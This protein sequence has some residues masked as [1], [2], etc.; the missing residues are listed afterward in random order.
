MKVLGASLAVL[1]AALPIAQKICDLRCADAA[2][3]RTARAPMAE[4]SLSH[5]ENRP[6]L[7][8]E[9]PAQCRHGRGSESFVAASKTGSIGPAPI[10]PARAPFAARL[11]SPPGGFAVRVFATE[12]PPEFFFP[13]VLRL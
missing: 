7:G 4:H 11:A 12:S 9:R 13:T 1:L 10:L 5:A 8:T 3:A 2:G 6:P